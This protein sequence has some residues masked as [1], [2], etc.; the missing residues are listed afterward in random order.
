MRLVSKL[1]NS[2]LRITLPIQC[3]VLL[4]LVFYSLFMTDIN[5]KKVTSGCYKTAKPQHC[6][7]FQFGELLFGFLQPP[8][9]AIS[10][11]CEPVLV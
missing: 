11:Q 3:L 6:V 10:A 5:L 9:C 4:T 8:A 2:V 7:G 1:Y